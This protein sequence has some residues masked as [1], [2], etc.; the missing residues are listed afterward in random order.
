MTVKL[1]RN[2]IRANG[3]SPITRAPITVD[4][5]RE[6]NALYE[7][8][9]KEKGRNAESVHPS[10]RRWRESGNPT[11]RRPLKMANNPSHPLPSAPPPAFDA[12]ATPTIMA[13][14]PSHH[15]PLSAPPAAFDGAATPI[16][17]PGAITTSY[18]TTEEE[19]RA[20][21]R[22][23]GGVIRVLLVFFVALLVLVMMPVFMSVGDNAGGGG[24]GYSS[25][26]P[27]TVPSLEP[28]TAPV[29]TPILF[30]MTKL[31]A[32]DGRAFVDPSDSKADRLGFSVAV[33]DNTLIIGERYDDG[34]GDRI[35]S[36][37][38]F[39]RDGD[40]TWT[41]QA[42]LTPSDGAMNDLFGYAVAISGDTVVVGA[43][44][45]YESDI[46]NGRVYVFLRS[47]TT[48]TEQVIMTAS[49]GAAGDGFG[50]SV[51]IDKNTV[52]IGARSD[53][54]NNGANSGSAYVF[55]RSGISWT[56]QAKL[57]ADDGSV[58]HQFGF[59]VAI[60][61]DRFTTP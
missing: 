56:Q 44:R 12:V 45:D 40:G 36:A 39:I 55:I 32:F 18:P 58:G 4:E 5:L 13:N 52:V 10:I 8:I 43:P 31:T 1:S 54:T 34:K 61:T 23:R 41:A 57:T 25:A 17:V 16:T 37:Y 30:E 49:D 9:Q 35:G 15:Q 7:L 19:L 28:T 29:D 21:R 51:A 59:S 3:K 26:L 14:N 6:N 27:P 20:R 33:D 46:G 38:I 53:D 24:G 48:W 22:G 11:S 47:N 2:W 60:D 42:N 50:N